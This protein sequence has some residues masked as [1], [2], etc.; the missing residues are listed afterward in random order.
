M[1]RLRLSQRR[2]AVGLSQ[3]RLAEMLDVD[4]TTVVRWEA[5]KSEPMP[6]H[7]PK[8]ARA[9]KVSVEELAVLLADVGE[10]PAAARERLDYVMTHPGSV[11]L[12]AAAYL[13]QQIQELD[14]RY[15]ETPSSTLLADAGQLHGQAVYLRSFAMAGKIR[16][17]LWAAEAESALLMGQLVWDASQRRDHDGANQLFDR[18]IAAAVEASDPITESC[19]QLRKCYVSLYGANDPLNGLVLARRASAAGTASPV[20]SGLAS[21]HTAEAHAM[22]K[23]QYLCE[24]SLDNGGSF[25]G[26]RR[27]D[28]PAGPLFCPTTHGRLAGSCYLYLDQ[29]GKAQPILEAAHKLLRQQ[30]KS[31]AIVLGNLSLAHIR[32]KQVDT[33]AIHLHQAIDVLERTRGGGGLNVVFTA[34]RE[35]RPWRNELVVAEVNDRLLTLMSAA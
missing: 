22:L 8:L 19:A 20:L 35:L 7:R 23:D 15:D 28:D 12:V 25:F 11:D 29:P 32:Q 34:A 4:R 1:K 24:Q 3:E 21:L 17:E 27:Q 18:A 33:A 14:K 2:K 30:K 13:R 9:L 5:A 26:N 16:R 10:A 31:T 6:W